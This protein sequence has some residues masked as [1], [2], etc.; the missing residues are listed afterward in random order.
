MGISM[1]PAV[2]REAS[3]T[4]SIRPRTRNF[5]SSEETWNFT[6]R[7]ERFRLEAISLLARLFIKSERTSSSLR[8]NLTWRRPGPPETCR[9][10]RLRHESE[11]LQYS[12]HRKRKYWGG[13]PG[14]NLSIAAGVHFC[15]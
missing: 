5:A 6:V 2:W 15:E 10:V 8:V 1:A 12:F 9:L 3:R 11:P 4:N 14:G 7:S 13:K